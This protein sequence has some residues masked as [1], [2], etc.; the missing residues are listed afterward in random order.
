M[1]YILLEDGLFS[2][3]LDEARNG[4]E[5][6]AAKNYCINLEAQSTPVDS[7]DECTDLGSTPLLQP[8]ERL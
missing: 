8:C 2:T 6:N 7:L 4:E 1:T 3:G 5:L